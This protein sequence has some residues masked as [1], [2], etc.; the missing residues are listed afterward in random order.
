MGALTEAQILWRDVRFGE[1]DSEAQWRELAAQGRAIRREMMR[2][3]RFALRGNKEL[4]DQVKRVGRGRSFSELVED[5]NYIALIA[6]EYLPKLMAVG[7]PKEKLDVVFSLARTMSET[8]AAAAVVQARSGDAKLLR[9]QVYS[10]LFEILYLVREYGR[11]A[12][13]ENPPR[14]K[15][16]KVKCYIR[17][18]IRRKTREAGDTPQKEAPK[19]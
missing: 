11:F 5:I 1:V 10:Y 4:R 3:L 12:L 2:Y 9:D 15:G 8:R 7:M 19:Q 18:S 16:Y 6:N 14:L 17:K 13:A